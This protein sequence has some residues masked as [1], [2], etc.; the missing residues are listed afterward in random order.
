LRKCLTTQSHGGISSTEAP[1][2]LMTLAFVDTHTTKPASTGI[3][4]W[5][6]VWFVWVLLL[7]LLLFL[8]RISL[9]SPGCPKLGL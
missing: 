1:S 2:S 8:D 5:G 9:C 6:C 7:L 3:K 4:F